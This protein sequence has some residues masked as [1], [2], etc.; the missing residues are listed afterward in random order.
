MDKI[1]SFIER[2]RVIKGVNHGIITHHVPPYVRN[3]RER[4]NMKKGLQTRNKL[5][6]YLE[7]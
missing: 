3:A 5:K 7:S 1:I 6:Y 4:R 2:L